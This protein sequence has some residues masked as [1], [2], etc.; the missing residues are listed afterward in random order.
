MSINFIFIKVNFINAVTFIWITELNLSKNRIL[1]ISVYPEETRVGP[2]QEK[3]FSKYL[4][5]I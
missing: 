1:I 4:V 2:L 3:V 5:G